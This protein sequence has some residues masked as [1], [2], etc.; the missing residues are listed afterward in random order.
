MSRGVRY[1]NN[2]G[3]TAIDR[4]CNS[5]CAPRNMVGVLSWLAAGPRVEVD[6]RPELQLI[7]PQRGRSTGPGLRALSG[8]TRHWMGRRKR[9]LLVLGVWIGILCRGP[10]RLQVPQ[11]RWPSLM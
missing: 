1:R 7:A 3:R 2:F 5:W 8:L 11:P 6:A 10:I 9:R 4:T